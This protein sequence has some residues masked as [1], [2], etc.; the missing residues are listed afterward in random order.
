MNILIVGAGQVG[1]FLSERLSLERHDVTLIDRDQ[2]H[3]NEAQDR[4]NVLTVLGNGA[5][6]EDMEKAGIK[7]MDIVMAVTDLDEVNILA[8]LLA[9][10]YGVHRRI[11]RI[12]SIDYQSHGAVL[13]KEKLG[14]DL[15]IN[16]DDAVADE[17]A[18]L[19]GRAGTFDVAEFVGGEIQFLGYRI[20]ESSP[21]CNLTLRELGEI[22]GMYRFI[23]AAITRHGQTIIPRGDDTIQVG[24]SIFIFA[25]KE[26]LPAIQYML[27]IEEEP[28]RRTRRAF[29]LGGSRIGLRLARNLEERHFS[30]RL[31]ERDPSRC[32]ALSAK[33]KKTMV[34]QAEGADIRTLLDEGV[35]RADVFIAVTENDETN[36]L[37]SLL[38]R[39]H[40]TSRTLALVSRP[41]LLDLAPSLGIDACVSPRLSAAGAILKYV[42]RGDVLSLAAVEGSNSEVLEILI[43]EDSL[44]VNTPLKDLNVP[45][46]ALIGIIVHGDKFQIPD[47]DS[48]L[49][50]G[51]RVLVFSLPAALSKVERFF[52]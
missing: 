45:R 19:A 48:I 7:D 24:D 41:E 33:L 5:S 40:G 17:L 46:G 4:L 2:E 35:G 3:L 28:K 13:S 50:A 23:I 22:R 49:K 26:E 47:G 10:E 38:C 21:L 52:E 37:C 18:N 16:P 42:R 44:I 1:Q 25:H 34:I 14:I 9:R 32:E 11:A 30:V 6:A 8:C 39:H 31:V 15:M 20:T 43:K 36:I 12:K 29:I 51:D 27:K